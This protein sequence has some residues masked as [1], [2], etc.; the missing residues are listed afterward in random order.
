V[1]AKK[2]LFGVIDYKYG[3]HVNAM[4]LLEERLARTP[5]GVATAVRHGKKLVLY[6]VPRGARS[7]EEWKA[8]EVG[9]G[10]ARRAI[11]SL[12]RAPL[13]RRSVWLAWGVLGLLLW[14]LA[15]RNRTG[16]GKGAARALFGLCAAA[17]LSL[18]LFI[19]FEARAAL[20]TVPVP[21]LLAAHAVLAVPLLVA[22]RSLAL[23][24]RHR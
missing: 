3:P 8:A 16:L 23:L 14:W 22:S 6:A 2:G 4:T 7:S 20:G 18:M 12:F 19:W 1:D 5:D 9:L 11:E 21:Y 17:E 10:G 13:P 15:T 24:E